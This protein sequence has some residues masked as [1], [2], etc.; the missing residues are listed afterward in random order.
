[1][2][3]QSGYAERREIQEGLSCPICTRALAPAA[4]GLFS[5]DSPIGACGTC[6]GF[7]RVIGIDLDKVVPD[8]KKTIKQRAIRPW[9]GKSTEWE[10]A[11][12]R[13]LCARHDIPIDV[14]F[15]QLSPEQ[16][17][18]ILY[19]D[20]S[21]DRGRFP[22]ALGWFSWMESRT[23]KMHV[24]V[25]LSKYRSYDPCSDCGGARI[26]ATARSYKLRGKNLAEWHALEVTDALHELA[27]LQTR[28]G[29]G[30]LIVQ[31]LQH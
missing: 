31:Q 6:R 13:K 21:W 17:K 30:Y 24:R 14:P 1:R 28:T 11:E 2:R 18:V 15:E 19:G 5:F 27:Q 22:G 10:R 29:Q 12:L 3:V 25:L 26:N 16:L 4:A 23:Y 20:G 7:G 9:S 8:P